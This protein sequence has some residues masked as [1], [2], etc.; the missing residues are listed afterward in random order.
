MKLWLQDNDI[1]VYSTNNEKN[2]VVA[3][4]FIITLKKNN[5][6]FLTSVSKNT[7]IDKL[8]D[9]IN[10]YNNKYHTSINMKALDVKSSIYIGFIVGNNNKDLKCKVNDHVRISKY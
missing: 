1:E 3:E 5:Y 6:K 4:K 10:E 7:Y 2:S 9:I 8:D